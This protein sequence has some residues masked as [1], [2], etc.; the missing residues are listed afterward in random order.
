[1]VRLKSNFFYL[2]LLYS[3][4]N[5]Q[6]CAD[7]IEELLDKNE[8]A[9]GCVLA[10][11]LFTQKPANFKA[12][13]YYGICAHYHGDT[14]TAMAAF[15]RAEILDEDDA[16]VHKYLGDLYAKIGNIEIANDEYD[17][18]DRFSNQ[19]IARA[20]IGQHARQRVSLLLRISAGV[21]S[22]VQ[23]NAELSDMNEWFRTPVNFTQAPE[24]VLFAKEY[25]RINHVYDT[26][27]YSSFYYKNQ[28]HA[29]NKNYETYH[30]EDLFIGQLLS[31]PGWASNTFDFWLPVSYTYTTTAYEHFSNKYSF[32]PQIRKRF[33]NKLL[34]SVGGK[35]EAE[36][37]QQW[38]EG[39]KTIYSGRLALSRW[40]D[41][42]YFRLAYAYLEAEKDESQSP[43]VFI[44]K[45]YNEIDCT[46]VRALN[47]SLEAGLGYL[48]RESTYKDIARVTSPDR[49]K[50]RLYQYSGYIS[51]DLTASTGL[52]LQYEYYDNRS[53]YTPSSYTKEVLT[54]GVYIY[55]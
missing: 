47:S 49:R 46:Y 12:N 7:S 53:N 55:L 21:D 27:P 24:T 37:Y 48:Y 36:R 6:I 25:L 5:I 10:E 20:D 30:D 34:L 17:K 39:D 42:N 3:F 22:N 31:G 18:A 14:D 33:D 28:L 15:D 38:E 2:L 43:R 11:K 40:F 8:Y 4:T 26:D 52:I 50:D 23:Y 29:Y 51:Y 45:Y 9:Q 35:Y 32:E 1:M 19:P 54:A 16:L 13:L 44:D 41:E